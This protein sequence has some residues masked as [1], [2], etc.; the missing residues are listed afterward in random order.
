MTRVSFT[1][2]SSHFCPHCQHLP[3]LNASA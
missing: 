3:R 2:R 1:N